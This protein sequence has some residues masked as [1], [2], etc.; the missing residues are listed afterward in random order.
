MI[1]RESFTRDLIVCDRKKMLRNAV[2]NMI[3]NIVFKSEFKE[4]KCILIS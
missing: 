3:L 2:K 1:L 4:I